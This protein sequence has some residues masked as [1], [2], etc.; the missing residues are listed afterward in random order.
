MAGYNAYG[1]FPTYPTPM[2]GNWMPQPAMPQSSN[3]MTIQVNSEEE[4]NSYPVAAGTTVL[5]ISFN[6]KK[7]WLKSTNTSGVPQ[8]LRVF[9]FDEKNPVPVASGAVTREEFDALATK[10]DK[11]ISDLGGGTSA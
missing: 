3:L 10:I 2:T 4:V 6:L 11:L 9:P 5:L 7:F 1:M 8:P